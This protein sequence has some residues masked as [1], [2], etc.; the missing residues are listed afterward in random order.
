MPIIDIE[1]VL[2]PEGLVAPGLA[3]GLADALGAAFEAQP[4]KIWVRIHPISAAHYAENGVTAPHPAFVTVL[5]GAPPSGEPLRERVAQ[6]TE[7]VARL[8][9]RPSDR[10][11]V[12][13]E[14]AAKG[15]IAFGG[16]LVE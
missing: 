13:F 12:L 11:H 3:Q 8:T 10:V 1:L 14:A 16:R 4:G 7:I 9:G 2:A 5:A 15:R 6:I